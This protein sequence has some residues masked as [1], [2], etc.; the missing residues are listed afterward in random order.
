MSLGDYYS[1]Y[2]VLAA[3]VAMTKGP[4]LE[5]GCGLGSTLM[6]HHMCT[7]TG[8][9]LLT[10]DH[11]KAWLEKFRPGYESEGVHEFVHVSNWH[12]WYL[13]GIHGHKNFPRWGVVFV[14][15]APGGDRIMLIERLKDH[16]DLILAHDSERDHGTGANYGYEKVTPL[17]RYVSEFRR[18]RPYTLIMSNFIPFH[19]PEVDKVWDPTM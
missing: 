9:L 1:H 15:C 17:F 10:A 8:R 11:D 7:K 2:P 13:T 12:E 4:V 14:D 6:L 19:M 5:L 18:A 3:A 16:A